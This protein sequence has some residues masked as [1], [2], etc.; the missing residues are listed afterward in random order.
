MENLENI[1]KNL[2]ELYTKGDDIPVGI[3]N[4]HVHI[5]K[6]HLEILFGKDYTLNK[7]KDLSQLGQYAC[8]EVV[9]ICGPKSCIERVRIL[10]PERKS[11]QVEV[12]FGDCMKLGIKKHVKAS[13]DLAGTSGVTIVGPK[14][15]IQLIEGVIV[16]QRHIHMNNEDAIHHKIKDGEIVSIESLGERSGVLN[17][18][19][20]RVDNSFSLECHL[21]IEEANALGINSN[22]KIKIKK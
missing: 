2:M 3:S 5:S 11:T 19:L 21:D 1:F 14:G 16:A 9:T 13:G 15:A 7:L 17:N 12:S 18:T 22:S 8:K 6:E 4:R 20:V 10:G